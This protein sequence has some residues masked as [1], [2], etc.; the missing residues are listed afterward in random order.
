[1]REGFLLSSAAWLGAGFARFGVA[2]HTLVIVGDSFK[3]FA[4][5]AI[6]IGRRNS[7][8]SLSAQA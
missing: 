5:L 3:Q 2:C 8:Q 1:V 7:S 4:V 6:T